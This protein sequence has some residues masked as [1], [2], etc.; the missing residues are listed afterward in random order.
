MKF[1]QK[2]LVVYFSFLIYMHNASD[3]LR[4]SSII[5][6]LFTPTDISFIFHSIYFSFPLKISHEVFKT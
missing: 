1:F 2:L 6:L 5:Y 3:L 4:V